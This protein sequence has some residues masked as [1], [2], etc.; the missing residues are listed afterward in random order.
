MTS[1]GPEHST[2]PTIDPGSGPAVDP[3][4]VAEVVDALRAGRCVGIPTDTVYGLAAR[5]D[6]PAAVES[7]FELKGRAATKAMAVLVDDIATARTLGDFDGRPAAL[8]Q[9]FWPGPLTLVVRRTVGL[10]VDLGGDA[11]TIGVRC[12][13]LAVVREIV[14]HVGPIVTTSAN[15]SGEP[16]I[17]TAAGI[18][19][20]F[21]DALGPVLD[22]GRLGAAASTVV[23][24]SGPGVVVLREGPIS[25]AQL[26]D[27]S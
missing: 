18:V 10:E 24:V 19:A 7:L 15:R 2:E 14:G 8:A 23:D 21:G 3:A 13:A 11:S 17:D 27:L 1:P 22:G 12:P 20:A 16:T 6:D 4:A 9:R 26:L 25:T 5:L